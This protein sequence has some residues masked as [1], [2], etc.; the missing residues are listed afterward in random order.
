MDREVLKKK[1]PRDIFNRR[2]LKVSFFSNERVLICSVPQSVPLFRS[3][4][5]PLFCWSCTSEFLLLLPIQLH[6]CSPHPS[7]HASFPEM[8]H[9]LYLQKAQLDG[10][11]GTGP[12]LREQLVC[13]SRWMLWSQRDQLLPVPNLGPL[14][15]GPDRVV[16]P[17]WPAVRWSGPGDGDVY[18]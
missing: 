9:L 6:P 10:F 11:P 14:W 7:I 12:P 15:C 8:P 18:V 2:Q 13:Q 5:P 3:S 1:Q 4:I 16:I 17:L